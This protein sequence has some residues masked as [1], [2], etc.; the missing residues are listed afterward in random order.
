M[1]VISGIKGAVN[2][3]D[4]VG[5]WS[6]TTKADTQAY[7]ASNTRGGPVRLPGNT[8]WSGSYD[9]KGGAPA[10]IP[11]ETFAFV[12]QLDSGLTAEGQAI[13][14]R[15]TININVEGGGVVGH[16]VTFSAAGD[17]STG[18]TPVSDTTDPAGI[19]AIGTTVEIVTPGG[20]DSD[21]ESIADLR[22]I[23]LTLSSDNKP[24][25]TSDTAG[26]TRRVA[27]NFNLELSLTVYLDDLDE[28]PQ[29]NDINRVVITLSDLTTWDVSFVR[30]SEIT[31]VDVDV[32]NAALVGA[33]LNAALTGVSDDGSTVLD[34]EVL[35]P[36]G[37]TVWPAEG[38][39][40]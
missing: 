34:G 32:D 33:T 36:N 9:A 40:S 25:V 17:L 3:I 28:V 38:S 1:S 20:S 10:V 35:D 13:V 29:P 37:D 24:Y 22:T 5:K 26:G 31:G 27:G 12:G 7:H 30:W 16:T 8:D 2:G 14:D 19:T 6:I 21:L 23:T 15:I 18:S 11:G 4:T 39:G